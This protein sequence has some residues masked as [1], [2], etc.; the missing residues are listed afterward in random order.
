[1]VK[2]EGPSSSPPLPL[3]PSPPSP[4]LALPLCSPSLLVS[5]SDAYEPKRQTQSR[6]RA[7]TTAQGHAPPATRKKTVGNIMHV[8]LASNA[9]LDATWPGMVRY[10]SLWFVMVRYGAARRAW[11]A[12]KDKLHA[13]KARFETHNV[14]RNRTKH[15]R[16]RVHGRCRSNH[17]PDEILVRKTMTEPRIH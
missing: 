16:Q 17:L 6:A 14:F 10:G 11:P 2:R 13:L 12:S 4:N 8:K 5:I 1:M 9:T 15:C 7:H 3:P